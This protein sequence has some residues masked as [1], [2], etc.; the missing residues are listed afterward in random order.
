MQL[1]V[2]IKGDGVVFVLMVFITLTIVIVCRINEVF[3]FVLVLCTILL[4]H[5]LAKRRYQRTLS[6]WF[7]GAL[8]AQIE[9]HAQPR[10]ILQFVNGRTVAAFVFVYIQPAAVSIS[11]QPVIEG[12]LGSIAKFRTVSAGASD[13]LVVV[14]YQPRV[15]RTNLI[16]GIFA[17]GQLSGIKTGNLAVGRQISRRAENDSIFFFSNNFIGII[18]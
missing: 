14:A 10:I 7:E 4:R 12:K 13:I 9:R 2:Q 15:G 8:A 17:L 6:L 3:A 18:E 16:K 5:I 1:G 11:F